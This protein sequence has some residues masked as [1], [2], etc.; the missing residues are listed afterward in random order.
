MNR[1]HS[2]S[3]SY[4]M[5]SPDS[6][7]GGRYSPS[8]TPGMSPTVRPRLGSDIGPSMGRNLAQAHRSRDNS[9]YGI[10]NQE[11]YGDTIGDRIVRNNREQIELERSKG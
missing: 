10:V 8:T 11:E 3:S 5:Y 9:L 1:G 2:Q 4:S 6:H 7:Y